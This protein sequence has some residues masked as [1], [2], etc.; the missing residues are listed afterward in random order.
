MKRLC[1]ALGLA[2]SS[3]YEWSRRVPSAHALEDALLL[4][5]IRRAFSANRGIYGS[6]RIKQVLDAMGYPC[7]RH[8]IARLMRENGLVARQARRFKPRPGRAAHYQVPNRLLARG[9]AGRRGEVWVGDYT[10][11]HTQRGWLFLAVVMDQYTRKILG[12]ATS[13]RRT[14]ALTHAALSNA[15]QH[16]RPRRGALFHSDQGIE[17]AANSVKALLARHHLT[18]SMS[19]RAYC[20]D[21]AHVESFFGT[22][23]ASPTSPSAACNNPCPR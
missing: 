15:L 2:R 5:P 9:P 13:Q 3:F 19:R 7:G 6:P 16:R 1:D 10:Y 22:L 18:Q 21:N 20:Y 23:K 14:A 12:W 8:R 11:I 17:Y 4:K